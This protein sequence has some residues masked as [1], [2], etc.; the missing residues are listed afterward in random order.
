MVSYD[1]ISIVPC[2]EYVVGSSTMCNKFLEYI[3]KETRF[4]SLTPGVDI[5]SAEHFQIFRVLKDAIDSNRTCSQ[6]YTAAQKVCKALSGAR[7]TGK[8]SS[9]RNRL[10]RK[11]RPLTTKISKTSMKRLHAY[12]KKGSQDDLFLRSASGYESTK[13]S[14]PTE[15]HRRDSSVRNDLEKKIQEMFGA[16]ASKTTR[17]ALRM[18]AADHTASDQEIA[19]HVNVKD[20]SPITLLAIQC[21]RFPMCKESPLIKLYESLRKKIEY[22]MKK[23]SSCHLIFQIPRALV[24]MG[25]FPR[26]GSMERVLSDI[27]E[28]VRVRLSSNSSVRV[29]A[30]D[31]DDML[32][33]LLWQIPPPS[34]GLWRLHFR[35]RQ[36]GQ[37]ISIARSPCNALPDGIEITCLVALLFRKLNPRDLLLVFGAVL[38]EECVVFASNDMNISAACTEAM[39]SLLYPLVCRVPFFTTFPDQLR[40]Q[41]LKFKSCLIGVTNKTLAGYSEKDHSSISKLCLVVH[42]DTGRLDLPEQ[43]SQRLMNSKSSHRNSGNVGMLKISG[44]GSMSH[45][46]SV[47][48][49]RVLPSKIYDTLYV[50]SFFFVL[51]F[52]PLYFRSQSLTHSNTHTHTHTHTFI[53]SQ[54]C[55]DTTCSIHEFFY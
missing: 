10:L 51:S 17:G 31:L 20:M 50:Y 45:D 24:L 32:R 28:Y 54:I 7:I 11:A 25:P 16:G 35:L 22:T 47:D 18:L 2:A 6:R 34:R 44:V 21:I 4:S 55:C 3:E 8:S 26:Y 29:I 48:G 46:S 49:P 1:P 40:S 13:D 36:G 52:S 30:S 33:R 14:S 23:C 27:N 41:I 9:P 12:H 43:F 39:H 15:K 5:T 38:M 37:L 42:L 53:D 19:S